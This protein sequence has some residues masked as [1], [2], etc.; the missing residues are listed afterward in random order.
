MNNY[1]VALHVPRYDDET[2]QCGHLAQVFRILSQTLDL[3]LALI[4]SGIKFLIAFE[5]LLQKAVQ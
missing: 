3:I 5:L 4:E 1:E 2:F